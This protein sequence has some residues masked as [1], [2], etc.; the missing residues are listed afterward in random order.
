MVANPLVVSKPADPRRHETI[1]P[2]FEHWQRMGFRF[3]QHIR[4]WHLRC[5]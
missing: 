2:L 1:R 3:H 4:R 5:S